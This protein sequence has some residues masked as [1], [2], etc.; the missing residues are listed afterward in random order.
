M[1][2]F[3]YLILSLIN[4]A[5]AA[6]YMA[7]TP[8]DI[9]PTHYGVRGEADA[10]SSK[11]TLIFIPCILI[12]FGVVHTV[13]CIITEN[14]AD[15]KANEKYVDRFVCFLF[16]MLLILV[17]GSLITALNQVLKINDT[18]FFSFTII[19][20]GILIT[21][22]SNVFSKLKQNNSFG[23]RTKATLTSEFIWK[24]THRIAA[25]SGVLGGLLIIVLGVIGIFAGSISSILFVIS[26]IILF[27]TVGLIPTIYAHVL[28]NKE[29]KNIH[30]ME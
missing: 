4:T 29:K 5:V 24:K 11:W 3:I 26:L 15:Y 21:I 25:Y 2:K 20:L 12:V 17:W 23:I 27:V 16:I 10:F 13:Y 22:M 7:L 30:N 18:L 8:V 6:L 19:L 1:K 9:V 28:Y 14:N